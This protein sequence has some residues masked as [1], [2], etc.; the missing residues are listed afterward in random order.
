MGTKTIQLNSLVKHKATKS[1]M[2]FIAFLCE[3]FQKL[4]FRLYEGEIIW[5]KLWRV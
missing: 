5:L 4:L 1:Q 2:I 3:K